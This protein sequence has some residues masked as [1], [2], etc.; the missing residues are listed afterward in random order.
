[1]TPDSQTAKEAGAEVV[2]VAGP[3]E[4]Q[5]LPAKMLTLAVEK[6]RR[7]GKH[8][9]LIWTRAREAWLCREDETE[10]RRAGEAL[11]AGEALAKKLGAR[12]SSVVR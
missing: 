5:S 1:M 11:E 8:Y 4:G 9:R 12:F 7:P 10:Y 2:E 6:F 3:E